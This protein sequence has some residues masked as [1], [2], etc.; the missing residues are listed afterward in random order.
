MEWLEQILGMI[1]S[2]AALAPWLIFSLLAISGFNLPIPEDLVIFAAA[3][4]G[5]EHPDLVWPLFY[6]LFFGVLCGD[7]ICYG[8]GRYFGPK[9]AQLS[10]FSS[11]LAPERLDKVDGFYR[12]YGSFALIIGRFIPFGVRNALLLA[13]GLGRMPM[14]RFLV[15]DVI[16]VGLSTSVYYSLYL[17]YGA[18][19]LRFIQ[20]HQ[21]VFLLGG[22]SALVCLVLIRR[23]QAES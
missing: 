10:W 1:N 2:N 15:A 16:A 11:M 19:A 7:F 3:G 13:A 20:E 5:L 17:T 21:A 8:L 4:L 23:R 18:Q 6:G 14:A 9:L 12:R 22:L